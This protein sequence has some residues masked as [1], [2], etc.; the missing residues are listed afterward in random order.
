MPDVVQC[1]G[2]RQVVNVDR[3]VGMPF[4]VQ[5]GHDPSRREMVTVLVGMVVI[6]H[7]VL[8]PDGV[9]R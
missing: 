8:C 9:W 4:E 5:R 1:P 3:P 2:C 7:C 6:H